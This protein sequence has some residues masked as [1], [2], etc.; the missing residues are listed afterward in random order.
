MFVNFILETVH[1]F[2]V[3]GIVF[4]DFSK[5]IAFS[6]AKQSELHKFLVIFLLLLQ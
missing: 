5:E 6:T 3:N 4:R 1:C 2:V